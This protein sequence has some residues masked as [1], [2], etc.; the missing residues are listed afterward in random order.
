M[1]KN[2]IYIIIAALAGVLIGALLFGGLL[3]SSTSTET[4]EKTETKTTIWTCAMHPQIRQNEPGQCPIC[5][6]DLTPLEDAEQETVDNRTIQLSE[7]ALKLSGIETS[8]VDYLTTDEEHFSMDGKVAIDE[9]KR[10]KIPAHF[11]GRIEQLNVNFTGQEVTHGQV[12]ASI[13]SPELITA[14]EEL[15][16]AVKTKA[17]F[18]ELYKAA[19][20]KLSN[21]KLSD[22]EIDRIENSGKIQKNLDIRAHHSGVVLQRL[23]T[24]G[25]HVNRGDILFELANLNQL[26]VLFDAYENDLAHLKNG[27]K[28]RFKAQALPQTT[29]ETQISFID[30][31]ID[32][33]TRVA[34]VRAEVN[35][36]SGM[37]KPEMF[38]TGSVL[39]HSNQKVQQL[40][41][42]QSAVLWTGKQSVVYVKKPTQKPEF[43]FRQITIGKRI[44]ANYLVEN[45]LNQG[46]EVVTKGAFTIDAAAQLNGKISMMNVKENSPQDDHQH[47]H[48]EKPL[49]EETVH[50]DELL[51]HYIPLKNALVVEDKTQIS[52][53]IEQL[54]STT[55]KHP[56][57]SSMHSLIQTLQQQKEIEKQRHTFRKVSNQLIQLIDKAPN[58][59]S[60]KYFI[61]FCPMAV[62][63]SGAY[64]ISEF[65]E[66]KNPYFGDRMLHCGSISKTTL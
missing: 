25:D 59:T 29:F 23:V 51:Q 43:E 31:V 38:I 64:W 55:K 14:Q 34:K 12:L 22:T 13:Y 50:P 17:Q 1:T 58:T 57:L 19:R 39:A 30:P 45:G 24:E 42:P 10:T 7:N 46:D 60:K 26:W 56:G 47:I 6:M 52:A 8:T 54:L 2:N 27:T 3:T 44:G 35:N 9:R 33:K 61:D 53:A 40:V 63:D 18:P 49:K 66:I 48:Y 11:H 20:A 15:L 28:I 65:E 36:S 37:L 41:V 62:D 21:W 5:G 16:Q 32:P 4:T